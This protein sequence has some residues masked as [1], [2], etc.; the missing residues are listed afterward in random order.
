MCVDNIISQGGRHTIMSNCLSIEVIIQT[1]DIHTLP[2][3]F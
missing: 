3:C 2:F 1:G